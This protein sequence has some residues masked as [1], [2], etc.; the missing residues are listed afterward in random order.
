M[1]EKDL[2]YPVEGDLECPVRFDRRNR[3]KPFLG[4]DP[5]FEDLN[6]RLK[7]NLDVRYQVEKELECQVRFD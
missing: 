4:Q 3:T 1:F 7:E 6:S 5:P 2:E